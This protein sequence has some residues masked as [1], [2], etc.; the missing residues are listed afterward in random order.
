MA[1]AELQ[2]TMTLT[3]RLKAVKQ[4]LVEREDYFIKQ[5][6]VW[7]DFCQH[8]NRVELQNSEF[9]QRIYERYQQAIGSLLE[10]TEPKVIWFVLCLIDGII[11]ERLCGNQNVSLGEQIDLLSQILISYLERQ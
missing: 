5:M 4:V 6:L 7:I 9:F 1:A 8:Q 3:E 2:E 11:V 10:I